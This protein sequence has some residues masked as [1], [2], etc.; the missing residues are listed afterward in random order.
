MWP[1]LGGLIGGAANLIGGLF[2]NSASQAN[3]QAQMNFQERMSDTAYQRGMA[4]MKAAGLNPILAYSQ[5]GASAPSGAAAPVENV[6]EAASRGFQQGMNSASDAMVKKQQVD[7]IAADTQLK[8]AQKA[9]SVAS[10]AASIAQAKQTN[11]NS[12]ITAASVP[13]A[14]DNAYLEN[15]SKRS[16]SA[17]AGYKA[18][19]DKAGYK[20]VTSPTGAALHTIGL[21]GQDVMNATSAAKAAGQVISGSFKALGY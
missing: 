14:G 15:A 10:A 2:Q 12:A 4:D 7:N 20:Y 8:D 3:A 13:Y 6:G 16:S 11:L 9:Q 18:G 17:S 5:G 1:V 19:W 21:A